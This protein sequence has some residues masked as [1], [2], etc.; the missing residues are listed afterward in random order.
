MDKLTFNP[1]EPL[2]R[3]NKEWF[4][5]T[6]NVSRRKLFYLHE[7][8]NV[9][10]YIDFFPSENKTSGLFTSKKEA[11]KALATYNSLSS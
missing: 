6:P 10:P 7:D 11:Y 1:P 3:N 5:A 9:Y 4:I 8:G 2:T